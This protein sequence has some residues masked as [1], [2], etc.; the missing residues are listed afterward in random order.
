MNTWDKNVI[1]SVYG[2]PAHQAV[3]ASF[4]KIATEQILPKHSVMSERL[5]QAQLKYST[6]LETWET[7]SFTVSTVCGKS[8]T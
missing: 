5:L 6:G 1:S 7:P 3:Q 8:S 2:S 4:A